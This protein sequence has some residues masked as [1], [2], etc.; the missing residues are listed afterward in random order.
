MNAQEHN[1]EGEEERYRRLIEAENVFFGTQRKQMKARYEVQLALLK[2]DIEQRALEIMRIA[3]NGGP[4]TR[5]AH[6]AAR[7]AV[8]DNEKTCYRDSMNSFTNVYRNRIN[9]IKER[10]DKN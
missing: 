1:F 10:F 2:P 8:C 4:S 9:H 7:H 5:E 3:G 6:D